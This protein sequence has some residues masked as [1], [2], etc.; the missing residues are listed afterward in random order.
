MRTKCDNGQKIVDY[1]NSCYFKK[2]FIPSFQEIADALNLDKG[3][4]SRYVKQLKL[5]GELSG[6]GW[7]ALRTKEMQKAQTR[8][9]YVPIVGTVACGSPMFAEQNIDGY[10]TFSAS[11]L[12]AG[13]YFAL[14][15]QG[16]SMINAGIDDGDYVIVKKQNFASDGDIVVALVDDSATL[17]R[18]F[19]DK[20]NHRYVLHPEN[21]EMQDMYFE[22]L[23]VQGVAK[24]IIK[25]CNE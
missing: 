17:K 8:L 5:S 10:L 23:S 22:R 14:K 7:R 21:D 6:D 16:Q 19:V 1:V 25:D 15:A 9:S 24:K 12:G 18:F 2:G 20:E 13:E 4:L 11:F 3:N